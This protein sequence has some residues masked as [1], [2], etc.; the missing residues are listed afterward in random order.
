MPIVRC[1]GAFVVFI[2]SGL[3]EYCGTINR[4]KRTREKAEEQITQAKRI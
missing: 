4:E 1:F 2:G 3:F